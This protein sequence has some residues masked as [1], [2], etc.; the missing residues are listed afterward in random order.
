[1]KETFCAVAINVRQE[2]GFLLDRF[3]ESFT[4]LVFGELEQEFEL[5]PC[6]D[7]RVVKEPVDGPVA[8]AYD[9][10]PGTAYLF[11]PDLHLGGR[12]RNANGRQIIKYVSWLLSGGRYAK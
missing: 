8:Y 2:N 9:A 5:V 3:G 6:D 7:I 4:A 10:T 1:M 11:R 12:W